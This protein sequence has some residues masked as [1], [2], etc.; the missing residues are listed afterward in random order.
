MSKDYAVIAERK[1]KYSDDVYYLNYSNEF[2]LWLNYK[3]IA[4]FKNL[5]LVNKYLF[6]KYVDKRGSRRVYVY[7]P[8][9][10]QIYEIYNKFKKETCL[11][12]KNYRDG[13]D[14]VAFQVFGG[15]TYKEIK[16]YL[17]TDKIDKTNPINFCELIEKYHYNKSISRSFNCALKEICLNEDMEEFGNKQSLPYSVMKE[18]FNNVSL[19]PVIYSDTNKEFEN[20]YCYD[21]DSAYIAKYF[22]YK[23]PVN[24]S[25]CKDPN[26]NKAVLIRLRIKNIRAK[27]AKA[28]FLSVANKSN[29]V[30]LITPTKRS[31]RVLMAKEIVITVFWFELEMIDKYYVYDEMIKE[32]AW[33]AE[34]KKLPDSF[35]NN[36]IDTYRTKEEAKRNNEPYADKKVIL[37]RIHGFFLSRKTGVNKRGETDIVPIYQNTPVQI[38]FFVIAMQRYLMF[39]LIDEI[40]LENIVSVHTDSIKTKGC[41]DEIVNK[42]NEE[43][44]NKYSDTLGKLEFEGVMEKVVYFS[45]TRAKYIMDGEF[46]IKHGGIWCKDAEDILKEYTYDT[47]NKDSV[48]NHTVAKIFSS[49]GDENY[50]NRIQ[51]KRVFSEVNDDEE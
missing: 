22:R 13:K 1:I 36:V 34:F 18:F 3:K 24:F 29:G 49:K 19:A 30:K 50:L 31:K 12:E 10:E 11:I 2:D 15:I 27:S 4:S 33:I 46:K 28:C 9:F 8:Y 25:F 44:K 39:K 14:V 51:E 26:S 5:K 43:H 40:G 45:N 6:D 20:V 16:Y 37:N 48:Y 47:F 41:Y 21:F 32:A 23:V 38:S 35:L 42:W 7:T 17:G